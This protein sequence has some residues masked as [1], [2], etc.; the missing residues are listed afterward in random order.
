VTSTP[1]GADVYRGRERLGQTPLQLDRPT[2]VTRFRFELAGHRPEV[3]T[4]APSESAV[5]VTLAKR[6][7][8][9]QSGAKQSD[10]QPFN[11]NADLKE[12]PF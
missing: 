4:V 2:A 6:G 11:Q 1:P 8:R 5:D 10:S 9:R 3:R 7:G 12:N